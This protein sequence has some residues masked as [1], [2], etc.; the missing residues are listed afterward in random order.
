MGDIDKAG[1]TL[2]MAKKINNM[3]GENLDKIKEKEAEL[4]AFVNISEP[5]GEY[6]KPITIYL[7]NKNNYE[8]HYTVEMIQM[9]F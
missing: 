2:N 5:S 6:S 8:I 1:K 7:T 3:S 4:N 9:I